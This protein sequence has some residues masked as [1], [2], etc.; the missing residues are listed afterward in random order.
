LKTDL[1]FDSKFEIKGKTVS[2][3]SSSE[4]FTTRRRR[5]CQ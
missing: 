2:A 5:S 1:I 4:D 3:L